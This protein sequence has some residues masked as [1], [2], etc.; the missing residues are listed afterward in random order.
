MGG[1]EQPAAGTD[2]KGVA[3]LAVTEKLDTPLAASI[4]EYN[5]LSG[6]AKR[7][8]RTATFF[9]LQ[10]E[11]SGNLNTIDLSPAIDMQY[12]A[13]ELSF[14]EKFEHATGTLIR[15]GILQRKLDV[16]GYAR[17]IPRAMDEFERYIE[18]LPIINTVP[19]FS[20]FKLR[21]MLRAICQF[22]PGKRFTL[23]GLKAFALFLVCFSRKDCRYGLN[24][25]FPLPGM[26]DDQLYQFCKE[27][28]I[29]QDLRNRAAHEGFHPD[30]SNDLGAIWEDTAK[31]V[32]NMISIEQMVANN[33][34]VNAMKAGA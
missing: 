6:E 8:L 28:H 19:F 26:T 33:S 12:K 10:V 3:N 13:L 34:D 7:A 14:R 16:I 31:I 23:D 5:T 9:H 17:P 22:R 4:A 30:A 25:L 24:D 20:R 29:F 18:S 2:D 1:R 32:A 21:K 15:Q 27:L 11:T